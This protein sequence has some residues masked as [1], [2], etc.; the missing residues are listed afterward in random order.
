MIIVSSHLQILQMLFTETEFQK[1][2]QRIMFSSL[3]KQ[4]N[5]ILRDVLVNML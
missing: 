2:L 5:L 1:M 3:K 4:F